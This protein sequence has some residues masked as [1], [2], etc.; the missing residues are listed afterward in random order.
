MCRTGLFLAGIGRIP[1]C[2][3]KKTAVFQAFLGK[4]GLGIA[5]CS[6]SKGVLFDSPIDTMSI[7]QHAQQHRNKLLEKSSNRQKHWNCFF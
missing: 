3:W 6:L 7:I 4:G 2:G 5:C 1:I